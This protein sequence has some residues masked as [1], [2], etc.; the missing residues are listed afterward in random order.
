[1]EHFI[2]GI[3]SR[4]DEHKIPYVMWGGPLLA[5]YGCPSNTMSRH[6][7][8][9]D[10]H[11]IKRARDMLINV[12]FNRCKEEWCGWKPECAEHVHLDGFDQ[13]IQLFKH[14]DVLWN[15]PSLAVEPTSYRSNKKR[16]D[17]IL[18][19][20]QTRTAPHNYCLNTGRHTSLIHPIRIP[21]AWRLIEALIL[22][23]QRNY[24]YWPY[25]LESLTA[26]VFNK[27]IFSI[28]DLDPSHRRFF[29]S[30][31]V[32]NSMDYDDAYQCI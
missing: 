20:D 11:M 23:D 5:V 32:E 18:S 9:I 25:A 13:V 10:D 30:L 22:K 17:I 26:C 6:A 16:P 4:F 29:E 28:N 21:S 24:C 7:F 2:A 8:V 14:S 27:N 1:D 3:A 12:G 19:C 15:I 31:S